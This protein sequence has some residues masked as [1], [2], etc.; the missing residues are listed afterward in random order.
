MTWRA[1][2]VRPWSLVRTANLRSKVTAVNATLRIAA[3]AKGNFR[4]GAYSS[5]FQLNL[6]RYFHS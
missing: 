6:S 3:A 4:A 1:L 2:S 5:T